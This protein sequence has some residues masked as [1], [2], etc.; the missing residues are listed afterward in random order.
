ML[1]TNNIHSQQMLNNRKEMLRKQ[2][3]PLLDS[4]FVSGLLRRC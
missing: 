3:H 2:Q 4:L 1:K